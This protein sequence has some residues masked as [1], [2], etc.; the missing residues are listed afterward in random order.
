[1]DDTLKI[2]QALA[3]SVDL[4]IF[5]YDVYGK[6][7]MKKAKTSPDAYIQ[8]ALQLAYYRVR[9]CLMFIKQWI[10]HSLSKGYVRCS[11]AT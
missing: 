2:A 8:M 7:F 9:K 3:D 1:M 5:M 6:G 11:I 4:H 10:S